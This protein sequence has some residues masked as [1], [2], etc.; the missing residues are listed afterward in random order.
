MACVSWLCLGLASVIL[1]FLC[2]RSSSDWAYVGGDSLA[3]IVIPFLLITGLFDLRCT[4]TGNQQAREADVS[5]VERQSKEDRSPKFSEFSDSEASLTAVDQECSLYNM[6]HTNQIRVCWLRVPLYFL[7]ALGVVIVFAAV[8]GLPLL[9]GFYGF[10]AFTP[11]S[12]QMTR[13]FWIY[14]IIDF[15]LIGG[16][17]VLKWLAMRRCFGFTQSEVETICGPTLDIPTE[18]FR[19]RGGDWLYRWDS[20]GRK[21]PHM[22]HW[23]GLA[24]FVNHAADSPWG[25]LQFSS[26]GATSMQIWKLVSLETEVF[27]WNMLIWLSRNRVGTDGFARR[28]NSLYCGLSSTIGMGIVIPICA[29]LLALGRDA[30]TSAAYVYILTMPCAFGD[31]LA[32]VVGVNGKIRFNVYGIGEINNK[33]VEGMLAMFFGSVIPSLPYAWAVGGWPWLCVV[34]VAATIG[35]TWSPRGFDNATIPALTALGAYISLQLGPGPQ[36]H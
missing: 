17:G 13:T 36:G 8:F 10:E 30:E 22:L 18:N 24:V 21:L 35:E 28:M 25:K 29:W 31:C 14:H 20:W 32:E 6:V 15:G 34:A 7:P 11:F 12:S 5:E 3:F 16:L 19:E 1:I 26:M 2:T 23:A 33:S 9:R 4:G 27:T